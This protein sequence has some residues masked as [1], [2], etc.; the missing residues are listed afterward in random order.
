MALW[1]QGRWAELCGCCQAILE[2]VIF[3]H[4]DDSNW[5]VWE[6]SVCVFCCCGCECHG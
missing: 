2:N 6:P 4:Q 3:V 1:T 5:Y